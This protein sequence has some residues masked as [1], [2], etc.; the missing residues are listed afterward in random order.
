VDEV[1][2]SDPASPENISLNTPF[3]FWQLPS[4]PLTPIS[5][6]GRTAGFSRRIGSKR[7]LVSL[8]GSAYFAFGIGGTPIHSFDGT[9][10]QTVG[11][12]HISLG[13]QGCRIH[14]GIASGVGKVTNS[15]KVA[16]GGV[17]PAGSIT[18]KAVVVSGSI[19]KSCGITHHAVIHPAGIFT[20]GKATDEVI[21]IAGSIRCSGLVT[22]E[23][24][25]GAGGILGA[26]IITD[27]VL[28]LPYLLW[29]G[30][31]SQ[32]R[33]KGHGSPAI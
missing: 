22:K 14:Q 32:G 13:T 5:W 29:E 11:C 30:S 24:I 10:Y 9:Q 4:I 28:L 31:V 19:G 16:S 15:R 12:R 7:Q 1:C 33:N 18:E 17:G 2:Y 27:Q 20:A 8:T 23:V 26:G 21:K 25:A 6:S 3:F